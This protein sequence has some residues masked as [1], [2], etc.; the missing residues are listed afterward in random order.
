ML[1]IDSLGLLCELY[2]YI[3]R[4][5]K[6]LVS[7]FSVIIS[8]IF[9]SFSTQKETKGGFSFTFLTRL[10]K[11]KTLAY[12]SLTLH[13]SKLSVDRRTYQKKKKKKRPD[14]A[15][16]IANSKVLEDTRDKP[17]EAICFLKNQKLKDSELEDYWT[18][19]GVVNS[20][21][22]NSKL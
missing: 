11:I 22:E 7:A 14:T 13:F 18:H 10:R 21:P 17:Q 8:F 9:P 2:I 20:S 15:R 1:Y 4:L 16:T 19:H 5:K 12:R 6:K 3:L